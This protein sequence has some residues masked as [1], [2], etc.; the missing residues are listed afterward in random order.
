MEGGVDFEVTT[1][2]VEKDFMRAR[3]Y[4]GTGSW[5]GLFR[6]ELD[7]L[8]GDVERYRISDRGCEFPC[9]NPDKVGVKNQYTYVVASAN[10]GS[11]FQPF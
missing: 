3:E 10:E 7:L 2:N 1:E 8:S 11:W 4:G 9:V 6:H 5:T